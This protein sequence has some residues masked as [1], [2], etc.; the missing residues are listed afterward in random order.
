MSFKITRR[1]AATALAGV[2]LFA[3]KLVLA[4]APMVPTQ[5]PAYYR[6]MLGRFEVTAL[7]DENSPWPST[8]EDLF[9]KLA[10]P[11]KSALRKRTLLQPSYDFSTIAFLVNTGQRLILVDT[12]GLGSSP[13]YGQLFA[14]LRAAGYRP[15][16]VD[17]ILITHM[18]PDHVG[19][20]SDGAKRMFP[21]A[22]VHADR[23]ELAQWQRAAGKGNTTAKAIVAKLA[24]YVDSGKYQTFDGDTELFAGVRSRAAYGHSDGHSFYAIESEDKRLMLWGDFVVN[25]KL[26]F[27][28]VDLDPPGEKDMAAGVALRRTMFGEA[29][30]QGYLVGGA[31]FG[32]P[33][34]G[35]VRAI[36][37][38]FVWVPVDYAALNLPAVK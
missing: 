6:M 25:D 2:I 11:L 18:H 15:E 30:E 22:V 32:F 19:G 21:N 37:G 34:L 33:G 23:R 16:Q 24:P 9:P 36:E 20:L 26:Q 14:N 13:T 28:Q 1:A 17:D 29:S 3:S 38:R 31:H 4:A 35:R 27:E 7:L 5:A 12:G 10:E 8:V